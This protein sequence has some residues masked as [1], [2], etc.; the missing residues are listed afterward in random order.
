MASLLWCHLPKE[1]MAAGCTLGRRQADGCSVMLLRNVRLRNLVSSIHVDVILTFT[2]YLKTILQN[3]NTPSRQCGLFQQDNASHCHTA[4]CSGMVWGTIC[5]ISIQLNI[6]KMCWT[7]KS[8]PT[9]SHIGNCSRHVQSWHS[10]RS[11]DTQPH[12]HQTVM[13]CPLTLPLPPIYIHH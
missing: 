2:T 6:Y 13:H 5:H 11:A 9:R 8:D 12:A 4:H 1:E 3:T 7:N 10:D